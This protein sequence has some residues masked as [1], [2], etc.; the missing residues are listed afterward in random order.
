MKFFLSTL[1]FSL[2]RSECDRDSL[3]GPYVLDSFHPPQVEL[4][5]ETIT[6][7][8]ISPIQDKEVFTVG[9]RAAWKSY[10]YNGGPLDSNTGCNT[11]LIPVPPTEEELKEWSRKGMCQYGP[12]CVDCWG[13]DSYACLKKLDHTGNWAAKRELQRRE[14]NWKF[15]YHMCNIDWRCGVEQSNAFFNLEWKSGGVVVQTLLPNGSAIQ[16]GLGRPAYWTAGQFSYLASGPSSVREERVPIACFFDCTKCNSKTNI[17]A[18]VT[19]CQDGSR[20]FKAEDDKFCIRDV[21]YDLLG[22]LGNVKS[23]YAARFSRPKQKST[24]SASAGSTNADHRSVLNTHK[25]SIDDLQELMQSQMYDQEGQ[26]LVIAQMDARFKRMTEILN[27]V[28]DSLSKIDE[29]LIGRLLGKSMASKFL[30]DEKFVLYKCATPITT[31]SN[32]YGESIYKDG[33]WTKKRPQDLCV[34]TTSLPT[35]IINVYN[36]SETWYPTPV[37]VAFRGVIEDEEGWNFVAQSKQDLIDTMLYTQRGGAG[38][39]LQDVLALPKGWLQNGLTSLL[40]GGVG[41]YLIYAVIF[42]ILFVILKKANVC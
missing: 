33:R 5:R 7:R 40:V 23:K 41:G 25:A 15:A 14:T 22:Q 17:H 27:M 8:R 29:R 11:E 21:C 42:L 9:Y 36:F 30:N 3:S 13:S 6:V 2:V 10:C 1:L 34:N 35:N 20:F 31:G 26:K 39:S 16:H 38:T 18:G 32:C 24:W 12:V 37:E 4:I 28:I 19:Y